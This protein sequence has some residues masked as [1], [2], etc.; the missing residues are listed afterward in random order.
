M[1]FFKVILNL[2]VRW[3][4]GFKNTDL[5]SVLNP[6]LGI[7]KVYGWRKF[8]TKDFSIPPRLLDKPPPWT[9]FGPWAKDPSH[10]W[11]A[12]KKSSFIQVLGYSSEHGQ[13]Q[14]PR[15]LHPHEALKHGP[16]DSQ[17]HSLTG[18]IPTPGHWKHSGFGGHLGVPFHFSEL[19][20]AMFIMGKGSL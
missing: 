3:P 19:Y 5:V 10:E 7:S 16:S 11:A 20:F 1:C 12:L 14:K 15:F 13:V 4:Q 9:L 2:F 6:W 17:F 18:L 8:P